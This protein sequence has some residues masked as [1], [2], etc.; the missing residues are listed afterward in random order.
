[1]LP[2]LPS[3]TYAAL[4]QSEAKQRQLRVHGLQQVLRRVAAFLDYVDDA[5][6]PV[7]VL[8]E[9]VDVIVAS[10]ILLAGILG[11]TEQILRRNPRGVWSE[12]V[13]SAVEAA[14]TAIPGIEVADVATGPVLGK[15]TATLAREFAEQRLA[16]GAARPGWW[17]TQDGQAYY[18]APTKTGYLLSHYGPEDNVSA[19]PLMRIQYDTEGP[20]AIWT[21]AGPHWVPLGRALEPPTTRLP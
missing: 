20:A 7:P 3:F 13:G 16:G 2:P 4:V 10:P 21:P 5:V 14:V 19:S 17:T 15:R 12:I 6:L 9:V 11:A 1:M 18:I 8:G